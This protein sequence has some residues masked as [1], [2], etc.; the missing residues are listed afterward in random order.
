M[1]LLVE[2]SGLCDFVVV[3]LRCLIFSDGCKIV[4]LLNCL[5]EVVF[6]ACVVHQNETRLADNFSSNRAAQLG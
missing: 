2:R 5:Y 6:S 1:T 3:C 4:S